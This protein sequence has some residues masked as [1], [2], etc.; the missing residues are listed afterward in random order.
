[1]NP[2]SNFVLALKARPIAINP[3]GKKSRTASALTQRQS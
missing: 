3:V 2:S 1:M